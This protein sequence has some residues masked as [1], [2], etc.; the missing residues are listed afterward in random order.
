MR[1]LSVVS[2]GES[3]TLKLGE[4][5]G[6]RLQKPTLILLQGDLGTGKSVFARG[7]ARGLGVDPEIPITSPTFTL[8]NHYQAR[9]D[10]YHFDL[11]RLSDPDELIEL[12]FDEYAYGTG[13]ALV[14]WPE[15]LNDAEIP[16]LWVQLTRLSA[17]QREI[18]FLLRGDNNSELKSALQ[19]LGANVIR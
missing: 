7:V 12:G 13:V 16:G 10:L 14:E 19:D 2:D 8:M 5:L 6:R 15:K 11:Y 4:T 17:T 1:S 3:Q 9:L 18:S